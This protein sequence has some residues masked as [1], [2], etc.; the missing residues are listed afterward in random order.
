MQLHQILHKCQAQS[1]STCR[2]IR[3]SLGLGEKIEPVLDQ[4][5]RHADSVVGHADD[6]QCILNY[7]LH[8]DAATL[9]SVFGGVVENVGNDLH[10]AL[11]VAID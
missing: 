10:Q 3:G 1:Q 6:D 8:A 5:G 2:S 7:T 9:A 11:A 4:F